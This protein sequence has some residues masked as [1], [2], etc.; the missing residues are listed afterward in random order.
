MCLCEYTVYWG[1]FIWEC[2][3]IL[4]CYFWK[5]LNTG[6]KLHGWISV[7]NWV[8]STK[9]LLFR[10][11]SS[12]SPPLCQ[13]QGRWTRRTLSS[14]GLQR[15]RAGFEWAFDCSSA[16]SASPSLWGSQTQRPEPT[17]PPPVTI[18]TYPHVSI[19]RRQYEHF[20]LLHP[21]THTEAA[22]H[23]ISLKLSECH[24]IR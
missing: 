12:S 24:C 6:L 20:H 17:S 8:D 3:V 4:H 10:A 18:H 16:Q 11:S 7:L 5:H 13:R 14:P 22:K 2:F 9:R 15:C 21:H 19:Y 23:A 1:T